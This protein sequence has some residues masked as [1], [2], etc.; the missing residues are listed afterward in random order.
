MH[1]RIS[2]KAQSYFDNIIRSEGFKDSDS[3]SN[4]F[5]QFDVYYCC[6]LVGIAAG[7]RD[8]NSV[9]LQDIIDHYPTAYVPS[10]S[11]I[12]G[13]IVTAEAKRLGVDFSSPKLE[14][15]LLS[16]LSSGS[17]SLSDNGIKALNAYSFK[18]YHLIEEQLMGDKPLT[19][20][21]F[22]DAFSCVMK[23]FDK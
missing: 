9:D 8:D 15:V 17:T 4:K 20:A 22:L 12:A 6:A 2:K 23:N 7:Q 1:F 21:E 18:G 3:S 5:I 13:L 10:K 19:R 11:Q 14:E 16:Y